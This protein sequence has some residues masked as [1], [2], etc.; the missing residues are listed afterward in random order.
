MLSRKFEDEVVFRFWNDYCKLVEKA[1]WKAGTLKKNV[2][3][4]KE[5][6]VNKF[7]LTLEAV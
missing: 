6:S 7:N 5:N 1:Y 2:C 4:V 3:F